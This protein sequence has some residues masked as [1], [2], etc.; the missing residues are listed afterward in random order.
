WTIVSDHIPPDDTS[1]NVENLNQGTTY[2]FRV[3]A[4]NAV[5]TSEYLESNFI[6]TTEEGA[7]SSKN[8]AVSG[9][10]EFRE[11]LS[12]IAKEIGKDDLK[13]LK[14]ECDVYLLIPKGDLEKRQSAYEVFQSLREQTEISVNNTKWLEKLLKNIRRHDLVEKYVLPFNEP[15]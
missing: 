7:S 10:T 11:M 15:H 8:P 6:T 2:Y 4:E 5:G 14:E 9:E 1:Y 3:C 12:K 13:S